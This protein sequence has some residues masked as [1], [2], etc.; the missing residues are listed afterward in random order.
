MVF[1]LDQPVSH[2]PTI[3][4]VN[5]RWKPVPGFYFCSDIIKRKSSS[6]PRGTEC[7]ASAC[8]L[9]YAKTSSDDIV[10]KKQ[11]NKSLPIPRRTARL[12]T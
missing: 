10:K 5:C 2:N 8:L 11:T 6:T 1:N 7:V 12:N 9:L 3:V 4:A